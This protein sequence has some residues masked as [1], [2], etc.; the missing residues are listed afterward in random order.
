[1]TEPQREGRAALPA[2]DRILRSEGG[3]ELVSRY[4]RQLVVDAVRTALAERRRCRAVAT[5]ATIV[6]DGS[7]TP[8]C[9]VRRVAAPAVS[10]A[11]AIIAKLPP[12]TV[13]GRLLWVTETT[14]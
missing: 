6:D 8:V 13:I 11:S 1:M 7:A 5:V 10:G 4:G 12:E 9:G 3:C 14:T 2:V